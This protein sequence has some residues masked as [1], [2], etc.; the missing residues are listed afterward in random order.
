MTPKSPK[1]KSAVNEVFAPRPFCSCYTQDTSLSQHY[2][3]SLMDSRKL[4]CSKSFSRKCIWHASDNFLFLTS[5]PYPTKICLAHNSRVHLCFLLHSA[6]PA[7][8]SASLIQLPK[9]YSDDNCSMIFFHLISGKIH[10]RISKCEFQ[11]K[12]FNKE[13]L[14]N[15][16]YPSYP[17]NG[18]FYWI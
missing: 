10:P 7:L 14:M 9:L 3:C 8:Q 4:T 16:Q 6:D 18:T 17:K 13:F 11:I 1:T 15:L 5:T 2:G 12:K